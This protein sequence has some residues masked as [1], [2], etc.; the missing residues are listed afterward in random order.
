MNSI[1]RKIGEISVKGTCE[2]EY[3]DILTSILETMEE[4]DAD[5]LE[6]GSLIQVGFLVFHLRK[7]QEGYVLYSPDFGKDANEDVTEDLTTALD[8]YRQ[9]V[10]FEELLQVEG[11]APSFYHGILIT[12]GVFQEE[13]ICV[14]RETPEQ[15]GDS[16]W[17]IVPEEKEIPEDKVGVIQAFELLQLYPAMLK[18]LTLPVGYTCIFVRGNLVAVYNEEGVNLMRK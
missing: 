9:Q 14:Q 5:S 12:E 4:M 13:K 2:A 11:D 7:K 3:E 8:I 15:E 6:D 18:V 1:Q 16:G 17:L 10:V